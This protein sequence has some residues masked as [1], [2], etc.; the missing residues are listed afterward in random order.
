MYNYATPKL[1]KMNVYISDIESS[2]DILRE[3]LK[4]WVSGI[5]NI[6][7]KHDIVI[8]G[9]ALLSM[10]L[11]KPINDFDFY[12]KDQ[13]AIEPFLIELEQ[14]L[15]EDNN[16]KK[17]PISFTKIKTN[18]AYTYNIN[19]VNFQFIIIPDFIVNDPNDLINNF[20]FTVCKIAYDFKYDKFYYSKNLQ[21]DINSREL[22]YEFNKYPVSSLMRIEKYEHKGFSINTMNILKIAMNIQSLNI[23]TY[24]DATEQLRGISTEYFKEFI[25][26]IESS[27]L[28][29]QDYNIIDFFKLISDHNESMIVM[30]QLI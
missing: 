20:D 23:K 6:L 3:D 28:Q 26:L 24:K 12:F 7:S 13:N 9:G 1:T 10:L 11:K 14:M 8:A 15:H 27:D 5:Y 29:D 2:L 19:G 21:R 18:N 16:M 25:N 4:S 30:H 17:I 22:N